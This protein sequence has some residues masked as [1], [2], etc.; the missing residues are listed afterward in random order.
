[1]VNKKAASDLIIGKK[2][3]SKYVEE[4]QLVYQRLTEIM[5]TSL[6]TGQS[7]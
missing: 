4:K 5:E 2:Y 1:M 7:L 6:A 3:I